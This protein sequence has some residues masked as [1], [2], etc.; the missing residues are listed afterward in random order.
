MKLPWVVRV[1]LHPDIELDLRDDRQ[2]AKADHGKALTTIVI[3][4]V[5]ILVT[6]RYTVPI[7]LVIVLLSASFGARMFMA[8]IHS[9]TVTSAEVV[10]VVEPPIQ[11]LIDPPPGG[12]DAA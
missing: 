5:L 12:A 2:P 8:F 3:L 11:R 9:R 4:W 10:H 1:V 6:I 7:G